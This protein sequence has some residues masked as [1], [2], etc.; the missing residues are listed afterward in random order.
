MP[1][2]VKNRNEFVLDLTVALPI[3]EGWGGVGNVRPGRTGSGYMVLVTGSGNFNQTHKLKTKKQFVKAKVFTPGAY[4]GEGGGA[5][6]PP[7]PTWEKK[8]RSE[9]SKRGEK[10]PSRYVGKKECTR[11]AQIRQNQNEK[12]RDKGRKE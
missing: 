7:T 12:G 2:A 10:V 8:F 5:R 11:S 3:C 4:A 1:S 6:E 9:M